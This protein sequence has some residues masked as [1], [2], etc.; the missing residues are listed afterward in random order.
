MKAIESVSVQFKL[1]EWRVEDYFRRVQRC[2]KSQKPTYKL[3]AHFVVEQQITNLP[4]PRSLAIQMTETG[5]W[6]FTLSAESPVPIG[7]Y[8]PSKKS[9]KSNRSKRNLI[10]T[11]QL[12]HERVARDKL[13]HCPHGVPKHQ[14]CAICDPE[15]F[16]ENTGIE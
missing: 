5:V 8:A 12:D 1:D 6:D 10:Y 2:F 14:V 13:N 11:T 15:K 9:R 3:I 7:N 4:S 16:R